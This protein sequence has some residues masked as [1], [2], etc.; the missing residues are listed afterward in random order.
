MNASNQQEGAD[1]P[2]SDQAIHDGP[3]AAVAA[4]GH[5]DDDGTRQETP[6]Q[7]PSHT[8]NIRKALELLYEHFPKA[9]VRKGDVRPLKI[10]VFDDLRVRI[11]DIDGL[12]VSK[13]RDALRIYT[14]RLAYQRALQQ[15]GARRIDLDGNE[16]GEVDSGHVAFARERS[17]AI[18]AARREKLQSA[19]ASA[20]D[21]DAATQQPAGPEGRAPAG[22]AAAAVAAS[23]TFRPV[24]AGQA[25][26][27]KA[28]S[29]G[30]RSPGKKRITGKGSYAGPRVKIRDRGPDGSGEGGVAGHRGSFGMRCAS[31]D[32]LRAGA[33]VL[34]QSS[35]GDASSHASYVHGV[36]SRAEKGGVMVTL[37]SGMTVSVPPERLRIEITG[38][39][40]KD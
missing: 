36:I 6:A 10:G 25:A 31:Q 34:V 1:S 32:D 38:G 35:H 17:E 30:S 18:R 4:D 33:A 26:Q 9:F 24:G 16:C 5:G 39:Q 29:G 19:R 2:A 15:D 28:G 40:G 7:V 11:R 3:A 13:V 22:E 21:S 8:E 14:S 23:D 37:R 27:D 12:S 20:S